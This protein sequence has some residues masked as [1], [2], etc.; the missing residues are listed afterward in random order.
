[1]CQKQVSFIDNTRQYGG[2]MLAMTTRFEHLIF[3]FR[4]C[5]GFDASCLEFI[6]TM[7][8]MAGKRS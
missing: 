2:Q 1:M 4:H 8:E 7:R 3:E 6:T 5:L